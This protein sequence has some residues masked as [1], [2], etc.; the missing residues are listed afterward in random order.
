MFRNASLFG[1]YLR[2]LG[3]TAQKGF[4]KKQILAPIPVKAYG[5]PPSAASQCGLYHDE[6]YNYYTKISF[7]LRKHRRK[8]KPNVFKKDFESEGLNTTVKSLKVTTSALHAIDDAGGLDEYLLRTP[9]EE[10]RSVL[11]EKMKN[12]IHFYN[13]H[14]EIREWALP[15]KS[16]ASAA[17]RKDPCQ[18]LYRHLKGKELYEKRLR[19]A[20]K[21]SSP[22]YLPSLRN[23]HPV[24]QPFAEGTEPP[25][26]PHLGW[27]LNHIEAA[28]LRRRLGMA[29]CQLR[30]QASHEE[31]DG[32]RTGNN[33]GGGGQSGSSLRK[34]SKTHK[35]REIRAY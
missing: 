24:R 13:Q 19:E 10:M 14:P 34:R 31:A 18:A 25:Q 22:Y 29:V 2:G 4:K 1:K 8:L 5:R 11:G 33:R 16:F 3:K 27:A 32:F 21:Q 28:A 30:A 26:L 17:A 12:V 35:W 20:Q 15:W 7:S 6:D 23:M 9:P